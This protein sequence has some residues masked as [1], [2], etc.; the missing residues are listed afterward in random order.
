LATG[1]TYTGNNT[2]SGTAPHYGVAAVDPMVIKMGTRLYVEGYGYATALDR[3]GAIRGR[4]IDLFF[5][6]Y[7]EAMR[8]GTR[9]VKVYVID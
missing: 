6:S 1:Y 4:R 7:N 2:A 9:R 8:W 3:G 5:E